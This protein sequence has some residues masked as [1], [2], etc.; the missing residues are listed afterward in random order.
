M[1]SSGASG[2]QQGVDGVYEFDAAGAELADALAGEAWSYTGDKAFGWTKADVDYTA[3]ILGQA[4]RSIALAP[5]NMNAYG[6]RACI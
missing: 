2:L 5:N 6:R 3:K 4:D 1:Q